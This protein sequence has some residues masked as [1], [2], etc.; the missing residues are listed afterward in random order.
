MVDCCKSKKRHKKC[1][2]KKDKK[3]FTLPRKFSKKK[4]KN[5]KGFTMKSSC[6]PYKGC[7]KQKGGRKNLSNN[8]MKDIYECKNQC[9]KLGDFC[10]N[11]KN[12]VMEK[13]CVCEKKDCKAL[14]SYLQCLMTVECLCSYICL[15]CCEQE[16]ISGHALGELYTKCC[17][18]ISIIAKVEKSLNK[19]HCS[20]LNC[21]G[22]KDQCNICKCFKKSKKKTSKR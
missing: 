14:K 13:M 4:C 18:M 10:H 6:A 20:Y 22:I 1:F 19:E 17:S 15:C 7:Y 5:P 8:I 16:S 3:I 11:T 2:R 12:R 9:K 21:K